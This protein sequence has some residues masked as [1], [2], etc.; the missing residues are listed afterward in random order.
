M[1]V[2]IP[3][4]LNLCK[5]QRPVSRYNRAPTP[6]PKHPYQGRSVKSEGKYWP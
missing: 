3:Q 4:R 6:I 1:F 5:A 2:S